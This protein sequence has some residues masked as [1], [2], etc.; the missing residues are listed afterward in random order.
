MR[1][2]WTGQNAKSKCI[3]FG[4]RQSFHRVQMY[5][6]MQVLRTAYLDSKQTLHV[7][8]PTQE[9]E[10]MVEMLCTEHMVLK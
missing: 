10:T 3:D 4:R 9:C 1:T 6:K 7:V 5:V 8:D 2:A